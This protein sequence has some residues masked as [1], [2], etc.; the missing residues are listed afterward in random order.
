MNPLLKFIFV[1]FLMGVSFHSEAGLIFNYHQLTLKNLDQINAMVKEKIKESKLA[2]SG[3]TVP[4]KE[5]LQAIYSRPNSD[6]MISKIADSIKVKLD[7]ESAY[8]GVF[9]ELIREAIN[10][11]KNPSKFK[12]DVQVTYAIFLENTIAE[13]KPEL[14]NK[15]FEY[16]MMEKIA[17][18]SIE[19]TQEARKERQLRLMSEGTSPSEMA[20]KILE[21]YELESKSRQ[22]KSAATGQEPSNDD[23]K[24]EE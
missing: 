4:L 11:L 19:L 3:K 7:E 5:A 15:G 10:A 20:K 6:D 24:S 17:N 8:E 23:K 22:E 18:S 16:K 2:Y 21:N 9:E 13:F 14:K 1:L 12:K